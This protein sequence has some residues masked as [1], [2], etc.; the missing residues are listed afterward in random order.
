[1]M[2]MKRTEDVVIVIDRLRKGKG[3]YRESD[4]ESVCPWADC[5]RE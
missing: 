5:K 4:G 3:I 2:N 1:M